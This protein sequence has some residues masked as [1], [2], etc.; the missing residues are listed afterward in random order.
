MDLK[1]ISQEYLQTQKE[2]HQRPDYGEASLKM[3]PVV[4]KIFQDSNFISIS[5]YGAG[6]KNLEKKLIE[7]GLKNFEYYPYDP[8]FPEYGLPQKADI[9]CCIDVLEHVEEVYLL[10]VLDELKR[11]T[12][13]LG[14]FSIATKPAKKFLKD[15]RNAHLIQKPASWWLPLMC[16]RFEIEFLQQTSIGF[17]LIVKA[18]IFEK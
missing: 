11:L 7:L 8:A 2:L 12:I 9:V 16:S 4:K 6:K 15:G 13:K 10:N 14:F 1:T 3:A 17:I 18:K 5:D